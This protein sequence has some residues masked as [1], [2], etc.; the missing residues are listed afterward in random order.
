MMKNE[1][2]ASLVNMALRISVRLAISG[3]RCSEGNCDMA[4]ISPVD[5]KLLKNRPGIRAK[6]RQIP[7]VRPKEI[8]MYFR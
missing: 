8:Q 2:Q 3:C 4:C 6:S 7:P 5:T 1:R